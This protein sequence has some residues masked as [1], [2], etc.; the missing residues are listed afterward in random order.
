LRGKLERA[1]REARD[2]AED[3]ARA[4]VRQL[5][6]GEA[7]VPLYLTDEQKTERKKLRAHGRQLG[8]LRDEATQNQQIDRLVEEV[9]YQHWHRMLFARF[10]A[11]NNL[12]MYPDPVQPI[13][14]T[15]AECEDLAAEEGARNGWELAARFAAKMLPQIFRPE[16]PIFLLAL[17]PEHERRL[18]Q[19][20][21]GLPAEVFFASDSLGWVYQFWQAKKKDEINASE[22]KI[23]A[24]ELPVVTQLFTEPYMVSF[25][26]DNSLG[27]W[28]AARR[29]SEDDLRN[30]K[31]EE[32]LRRKA[33]LPGVP[34]D[35]LRFV[36]GEDG[37]WTPAAGTFEGWPQNLKELKVLDP[38]CGSGH[39]LVAALPMLA[40]MRMELEGL[41]AGEA[42]DAVLRENLHGL[43][44]DPRCVELAAFALGFAAWR[45]PGAG[46]YRMLPELNL[47]CSGLSISAGKE[48]W[49][50]LAKINSNNNIND[51]SNLEIVLVDLYDQFKD[52]PLLGSLINPKLTLFNGNI[53][54]LSWE[55]I[56][57][58]LTKALSSEADMEKV[59]MGVV[60][61]GLAKAAQLLARRYHLVITNVPYLARG[62]QDEKLMAFCEGFFNDAKNDLATVFLDRCLQFWQRGGSSSSVF[63]RTGY[64]TNTESSGQ[65]T[66]KRE[67]ESDCKVGAASISDAHVGL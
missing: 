67:M 41:S 51:N 56:S 46:G 8:D 1:V 30:A 33:A 25:L 42:V 10:L 31:D 6:V 39:F 37:R 45:Y 4:A 52:A 22:V 57:P 29:L 21:A 48:E 62:K 65:T 35:Y 36:R 63:P 55:D 60:A 26:L 66:E 40:S 59:E 27:A 50:A 24:R 16:S 38:C 14:I 15:L 3:A 43:E 2:I 9:A 18:E 19:L 49:Q 7:K 58:L 13:P 12:L 20:L 54:G 64:L 34:L 61:Q 17:P 53:L 28:W 11:E 5:G 32:E 44:I 47:A 23:G